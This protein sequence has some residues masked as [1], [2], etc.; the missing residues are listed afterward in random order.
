MQ[1]HVRQFVSLFLKF[2]AGQSRPLFAEPILKKIIFSIYMA[3]ILHSMAP[4]VGA[5]T[6]LNATI[7]AKLGKKIDSVR[8]IE[9]ANLYEVSAEG[10]VIYIDKQLRYV[11]AGNIYDLEKKVNLTREQVKVVQRIKFHELPL[12]NAIKTVRGSGDKEIVIFADPNCKFC[13]KLEKEL[14]ELQGVKVFTF[15]YPILSEDSSKLARDIW[16]GAAPSEQWKEWMISEKRPPSVD[17]ESPNEANLILGKKL[18]VNA[19]PVIFFSDGERI[20]GAVP[21]EKIKAK[22]RTLN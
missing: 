13:K 21:L 12:N 4:A 14:A 1:E 17:C 3:V 5:E 8:T 16:C 6:D 20:S 15:L 18:N 7:S 22:L 9:F 11:F 2:W 10:K 19:T